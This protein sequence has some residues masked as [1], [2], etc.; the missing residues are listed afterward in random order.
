MDIFNI[1]ISN[2]RLEIT[3]HGT[4]DF[5]VAFYETDMIKNVM[6]YLPLHWHEEV[7]FI[8]VTKGSIEFTVNQISHILN[9]GDG[10]FINS[11]CIHS[12][13]SHNCLNSFYICLDLSPRFIAPRDSIILD[14]YINPYINSN[15]DAVKLIPQIDWQNEILKKLNTFYQ[16]Y[17]EKEY[18]YELQ[19]FS[20]LVDIWSQLI[21]NT[22]DFESQVVLSVS[23][24]NQRIK[25]ILNY[26]YSNYDEKITLEDLA[27]LADV[28][29]EECCR[30]FKRVLQ[31]TP[32]EY[33][34]MYRINQSM[35]L[36]RSTNHSIT[37]IALEIGFS[38]ASYYISKFKSIMHMTPLVFRK[39]TRLNSTVQF[40]SVIEMDSE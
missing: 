13:R 18:T 3:Q 36:L 40:A 17:L 33:L 22:I 27:N 21:Q 39:K 4:T 9:T 37:E 34:N 10:L 7:Q 20:L 29:R 1:P 24:E 5:P 30:L 16:I 2:N 19:A 6:G 8:W 23:K 28:S 32:I 14:K 12:A 11:G 35:Y 31:Q 15:H 25:N 26:I 38:N